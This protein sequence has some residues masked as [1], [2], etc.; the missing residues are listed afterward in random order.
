[1]F[2]ST[3]ASQLLMDSSIDAKR[4]QHQTLEDELSDKINKYQTKMSRAAL[5]K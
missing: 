5:R 4:S 3:R 1:M 2:Y